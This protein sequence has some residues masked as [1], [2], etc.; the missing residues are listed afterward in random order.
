VEVIELENES[1]GL[2]QREFTKEVLNG[3]YKFKPLRQASEKD[4][5]LNM[6]REPLSFHLFKKRDFVNKA[7]KTGM[8]SKKAKED[9]KI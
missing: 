6:V 3:R 1:K 2:D 9:D 7:P 8:A 4:Q 5:F